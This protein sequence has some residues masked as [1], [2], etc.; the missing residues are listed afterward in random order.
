MTSRNP[1]LSSPLL[2]SAHPPSVRP[3]P[4][5]P[6]RGGHSDHFRGDGRGRG[7]APLDLWRRFAAMFSKL[8][9][10]SSSFI[11]MTRGRGGGESKKNPISVALHWHG[12]H[13][14]YSSLSRPRGHLIR[15]NLHFHSN[16]GERRK[17]AGDEGRAREGK[18]ERGVN[19]KTKS[20]LG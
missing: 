3:L 11:K 13:P 16:R 10:A 2:S 15:S 17:V 14:S 12:T 6:H 8:S 9:S 20:S 4:S 7:R 18:R 19:A 5:L 1:F